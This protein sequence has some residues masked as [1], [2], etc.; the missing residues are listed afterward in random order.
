[1]ITRTLPLFCAVLVAACADHAIGPTSTSTHQLPALGVGEH[2][3]VGKYVAMGTS[4]SM[5]VMS[6]GVTGADQAQSWPAQLA[7][8]A[9][10]PF[11]Q[12]LIQTPGCQPPLKSPLATL[13]RVNGESPLVRSSV[14]APLVEEIGTP[15]QNLAI[16]EAITANAL[17]TT[18]E[19]P[20]PASWPLR[21]AFYSRVLGAGQT[22]LTA[23]LAQQPD[24]VSVE[25]GVNEVLGARSG[26]L[27]PG[28]TIVP[29]AAWRPAYDQLIA[30]V[31]TTG[32]KVLLVGLLSDVANFPSLRRGAELDANRSELAQFGILVSDDCG[33]SASG[34]F[35]YVP[36]KVVGAYAAA[37][38][39]G[40]PGATLSCADIPG[41]QDYVLTAADI[42]ALDAQLAEMN[43]HVRD[44]A[45]E[46][47]FAFFDLDPLYGQRHLKAPFSA[48]AL[49]MSDEPYGAFI[50]L[51]GVHPSAAGHGIF[52]REA[53]KALNV[54]Y[55]LAI[56]L[57]G[58]IAQQQ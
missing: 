3:R 57:G 25:F 5:G 30:G 19:S 23:M 16:S 15:T 47:G 49:L 44:V 31:K 38:A 41:T 37:Q 8:L 2:A 22:Q 50:S 36:A 54:T 42:N 10:V 53:A 32:A 29:A 7:A 35:I 39:A 46:N 27:A 26:L 28:L 18:P 43:A 51:D 11:S 34:N 20:S 33:G 45:A 56:P 52:A 40:Q 48:T 13:R 24:L 58:V 55:H 4:L 21:G 12:P 14:C 17:G 6:N 9:R 1:M